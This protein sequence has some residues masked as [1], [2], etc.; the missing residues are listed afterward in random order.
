MLK[1]LFLVKFFKS[2][3]KTFKTTVNIPANAKYMKISDLY[4]LKNI[5]DTLTLNP[6]GSR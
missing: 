3:Q 5:K 6:I 4:T 2:D 1:R